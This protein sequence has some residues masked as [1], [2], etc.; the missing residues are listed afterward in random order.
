MK[1]GKAITIFFNIESD[2]YTDEEKAE[3]IY[4]VISMPTHLSVNKDS[5]IKV[6]KWL[7]NNQYQ[8]KEVE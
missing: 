4:Q 6:T 5:I 3:A 2:E 1:I 7:W 8:V